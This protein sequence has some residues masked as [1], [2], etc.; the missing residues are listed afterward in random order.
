MAKSI[1]SKEQLIEAVR[2]ITSETSRMAQKV[3]GKTFPIKSLTVFTHSQAEYEL[4]V[5]ILE[6]MGKPYN[7]NNGPRIE[8]N[9]SI[10][11][12]DNWITHLRIRKPDHERPQV[13]C[14]DFETDY[15]A[16]KGD[17]LL[18]YADNFNLIKRPGYEMI[19][20]YDKKFD[21][22]AYVVSN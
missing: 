9:E 16:F 1:Q 2:Y 5:Q 14:N 6:S 11:A 17:Y 13:G 7:Y 18:K 3:V 20:L 21:V 8:L 12:D 15:E 22:F 19:E 4:L 10:Q